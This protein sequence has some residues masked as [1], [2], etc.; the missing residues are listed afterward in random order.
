MLFS[1][2]HFDDDS[3]L[4]LW[5]MDE[6]EEE[7]LSY[8]DIRQAEYREYIGKFPFKKRRQ[9]FLTSRVMLKVLLDCENEICHDED[10]KPSIEGNPMKISISHTN[11]YLAMLLHSHAIVGIDIEQKR[12]KIFRVKNRFLS[13]DEIAHTSHKNEMD[14]LLLQWSAKESM[15]K[16]MNQRDIDFQQDLHIEPFILEDS[17]IFYG[18]ESKT[19][20]KIRFEL[21][22]RIYEDFVMV[23]G[24][25]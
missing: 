1:K 12:E 3:I 16:M 22:Y 9:E 5:K 8:F 11:G 7:L 2:E 23:W 25:R 19:E 18:N 4:A 6:S 10:G 21:Y 24:K 20:E 17:G 15:F 13:T 14:H